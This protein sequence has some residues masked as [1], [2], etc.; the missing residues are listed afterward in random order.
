MTTADLLLGILALGLQVWIAA[1]LLRKQL[2]RRF[3]LF[4]AYTLYS[5][6]A[7]AVRFIVLKG[8]PRTYYFVFWGTEPLYALLGLLAIY[9]SFR[10][11]FRPLYTI[12]W[13]RLLLYAVILVPLAF[14]V[15]R[16]IQKPPLVATQLG[17]AILSAEIGVRFIQGCIFA[18]S[19]VLIKFFRVPAKRYP[20]GIVDGFGVAALGILAGSMFRSEFGTR[21]NFFFSFVP[22]VAYIIALLIWLTSLYGPENK[23]DKEVQ[24]PMTPDEMRDLLR[25][26]R[27]D[28][29]KISKHKWK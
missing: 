29:K 11:I 10:Q 19:Y 23:K 12:W 15:K 9:E 21:L 18:L 8:N 24:P 27:R 25:Q 17:A 16:I 13:F 6:A 5:I 28:V 2:H 1:V 4:V 14:A 22:V 7:T 3:P 26:Y 20:A